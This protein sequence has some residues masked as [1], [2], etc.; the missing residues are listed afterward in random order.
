MSKSFVYINQNNQ[1]EKTTISVSDDDK[2]TTNISTASNSNI[3]FGNFNVN[4]F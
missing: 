2:Y 3:F 4:S 1:L